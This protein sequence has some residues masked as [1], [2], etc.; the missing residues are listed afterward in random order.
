MLNAYILYMLYIEQ[1]TQNQQ[2]E[3]NLT[4]PTSGK[5]ATDGYGIT[6]TTI[7]LFDLAR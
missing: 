4:N 2:G 5:A 7:Q 3:R 6:Y 1:I